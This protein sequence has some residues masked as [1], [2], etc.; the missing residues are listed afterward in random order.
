MDPETGKIKVLVEDGGNARYA[1]TGLQKLPDAVCTKAEIGLATWNGGPLSPLF[2]NPGAPRVKLL[3]ASPEAFSNP[4]LS[5][6]HLDCRPGA[7][8]GVSR[9]NARGGHRAD[10]QPKPKHASGH[11]TQRE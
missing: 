3:G 9:A 5:T 6:Y 2:S 7:P 1:P 11:R 8:P 4:T 10:S